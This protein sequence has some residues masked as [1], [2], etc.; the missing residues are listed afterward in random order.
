[1]SCHQSVIY[2][3]GLARIWGQ[4]ST[5]QIFDW[6]QARRGVHCKYIL[7]I[8]SVTTTTL[9]RDTRSSPGRLQDDDK[10]PYILLAVNIACRSPSISAIYYPITSTL[11]IIYRASR[12]HLQLSRLYNS[13]HCKAYSY[14]LDRTTCWPINWIAL[15]V[16]L[17]VN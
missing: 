16:A 10:P 13:P 6:R 12:V 14:E 5:C 7:F 1:M 9:C 3:S 11:F 17:S 8:V 15:P 2:L 4:H